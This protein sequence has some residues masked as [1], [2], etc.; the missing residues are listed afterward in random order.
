MHKKSVTLVACHTLKNLK[1]V[2]HFS[3][4][5]ENYHIELPLYPF[6]LKFLMEFINK[7]DKNLI[8]LDIIFRFEYHVIQIMLFQLMFFAST[9]NP[10]IDINMKSSVAK[11]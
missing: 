1:N 8:P 7:S 11:L 9:K 2:I 4:K 6:S 5:R 10:P 3:E